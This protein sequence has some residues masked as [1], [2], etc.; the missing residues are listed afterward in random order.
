M[1]V[2]QFSS[3]L[4]VPFLIRLYQRSILCPINLNL[5]HFYFLQNDNHSSKLSLT[6]LSWS[7]LPSH[8]PLSEL[9][10]LDLCLT[11]FLLALFYIGASFMQANIT[12]PFYSYIST[13][14]FHLFSMKTEIVSFTHF[15]DLHSI[16]SKYGRRVF[17]YKQE[18]L[19]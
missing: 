12:L 6:G 19:K 18:Q 1:M 13:T 2:F 10:V 9:K 4:I 14:D 5:Y 11:D 3:Y 16:Y 7:S 15:I 8:V 17:F